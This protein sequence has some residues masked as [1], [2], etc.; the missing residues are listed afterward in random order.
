MEDDLLSAY[1]STDYIV[2]GFLEPIRI[3]EVSAE[4]DEFLFK[5]GFTEWAFLTAFNPLSVELGQS[6][7]EKR[8]HHLAQC[9]E[10]Y[11]VLT[12]EGKD[13]AG[14]WPP[15]TSF[16]I[17]GIT[18]QKAVELAQQFGQRA[19]VYGK[20]NLPAKMVETFDCNGN[21]FFIPEN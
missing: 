12:G 10:G 20:I 14:I 1:R 4:A 13:R 11:D 16:F 5:R 21:P 18:F 9:I 15:E 7:N 2:H 6:E 19:M 17:A 8:N 3:G